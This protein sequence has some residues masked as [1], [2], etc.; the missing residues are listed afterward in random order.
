MAALY[1]LFEIWL[2]LYKEEYEYIFFELYKEGTYNIF[3]LSV[4]IPSLVILS[5]F[6]FVYKNP[7]AKAFP[8]YLI[9][10][11]MAA[12]FS[13]FLTFYFSRVSLAAYLVDP[14]EEISAFASKLNWAY[15]IINF[16]LTIIISFLISFILRLKSKVQ[17]QLP[18]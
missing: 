3:G 2:G 8:D 18:F 4:L 7:Y 5:L 9:S 16:V 10:L 13:A 17:P 15:T 1:Q 6:Y 12:V 11:L 14:E